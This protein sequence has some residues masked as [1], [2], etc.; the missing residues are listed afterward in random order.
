[1]ALNQSRVSSATVKYFPLCKFLIE[2]SREPSLFNHLFI[3]ILMSYV[4][5]Y[6]AYY[7]SKVRMYISRKYLCATKDRRRNI[8]HGRALD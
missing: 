7:I 5:F 4:S 8:R 1:M 6:T 3:S 2:L